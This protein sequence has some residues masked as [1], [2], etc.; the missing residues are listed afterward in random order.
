MESTVEVELVELLHGGPEENFRPYLHLR[1]ELTSVVPEVELPYGVDEL[2]LRRGSGLPIDAFYNFNPRQLGDLVAKGYF[3]DQFRVPEEMSGIPWAI[4]GSADFMIV[5]PE[6]ED[7]P[8]LVFMTVHNQSELDLD[9]QNSGYDLSSYFPNYEQA[10]V[11]AAEVSRQSE[12][13]RGG[14][15]HDIF[16]DVQFEEYRPGAIAPER[17]HD[18]GEWRSD[19]PAGVFER[20]VSEIQGSRVD[21]ALTEDA[22]LAVEAPS[23]GSA[24]EL[25]NTIVAPAI[26]RARSGEL[27]RAEETADTIQEQ[28]QEPAAGGELAVDENGFLD[29]GEP[30]P[31]LAPLPMESAETAQAARRTAAV[32]SARIRSELL[33]EEP[34]ETAAESQHDL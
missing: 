15:A 12:P 33:E 8:P 16:S 23:P 13:A 1:G 19:V 7:Q 34:L 11:V 22:V 29:L 18:G 20:L 2:V 10:P 17:S 25:Y 3:T 24:E 32:R 21:E 14:S 4:P 6:L 30:D 28:P 31:E 26:E 5:A 9:E 27:Y